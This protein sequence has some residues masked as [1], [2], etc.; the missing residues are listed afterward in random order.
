MRV[1]TEERLQRG[2]AFMA[3]VAVAL[4]APAALHAES[5]ADVLGRI[6]ALDAGPRNWTD[7][8]QKVRLTIVDAAGKERVR[9]LESFNRRYGGG[10]EKGLLFF[11][12]PAE[13]RGTGFL[14]WSHGARDDEQWLFLPELKRTRQI[15]SRAKRESF[16]G[17]DFSYRDLEIINEVTRWTDA[18]ATAALGADEQIAG[19]PAHVLSFTPRDPDAVGYTAVRVWER[20]SDLVPVKME[21]AGPDGPL[22]VLDLADY[23]T[24]D[25]IP[26]P[27]RLEMRNLKSGGRTV[28]EIQ[29]LVHNRGL[30]DDLF[31]QRTLERGEP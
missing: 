22:K 17:T 18:E 8:T 21:F 1:H 3:T 30:A 31:S 10:E 26:T 19:E 9:E 12:A 29:E 14:Q 20:K 25:G 16:A 24:T 6:R 27:Y 2:L 15:S 28:V 4:V 13:L 11:R 23:R 7:R 5:A